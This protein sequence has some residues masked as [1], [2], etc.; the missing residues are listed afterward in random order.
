MSAGGLGSVSVAARNSLTHGAVTS[1]V[2]QYREVPVV[3]SSAIRWPGRV[4]DH[5]F[6]SALD[7]NI[8]AREVDGHFVASVINVVEVVQLQLPGARVAQA[9]RA[10]R[11]GIWG[12]D[13]VDEQLDDP[14]VCLGSHASG[15][16][17]D[18][19]RGFE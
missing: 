17:A 16:P 18:V 9:Q 15:V 7:N 5:H 8:A 10:I 2:I 14:P 3:F 1:Y 4:Q 19:R 12:I 13:P 6:S 11:V